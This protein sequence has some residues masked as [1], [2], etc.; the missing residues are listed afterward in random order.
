MACNLGTRDLDT[1][2]AGQRFRSAIPWLLGAEH[3]FLK[4][5]S[6]LRG[7]VAELL[8]IV[9][10]HHPR[11]V[12]TP[13]A[14]AH[15]RIAVDGRAH[16]IAVN[17]RVHVET[18][19]L[20]SKLAALGQ[21]LA[22]RQPGDCPTDLI[23]WYDATSESDLDTIVT[24]VRQSGQGVVYCGSSGL[25]A[26]LARSMDLVPYRIHDL[27][28]PLLMVSGSAHRTT[29]DQIRTYR[30]AM[31]GHHSVSHQG[32]ALPSIRPLLVT[33]SIPQSTN[34]VLARK[35]VNAMLAEVCRA[36]PPGSVMVTGGWTLESLCH[37][38]GARSIEP[39]GLFAPG[40]PVCRFCDGAWQG[41]TLIAKSG[42]FGEA[43]L[44]LDIAGSAA[45]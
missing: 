27:P 17:G 40:V 21:D 26:A 2:L 15:G 1:G 37:H 34:P 8:C 20:G 23:T 13:A 18:V 42:G 36:S 3:P 29:R 11:I 24:S 19:H 6:R 38:L 43:E 25:A 39:R 33:A 9:S 14:P 35:Y 4:I 7:H 41:R 12:I 10:R 32:A 5:D 16:A 44:L 28:G 22:V 31:P 45:M 30:T